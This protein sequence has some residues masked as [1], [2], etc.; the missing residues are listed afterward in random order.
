MEDEVIELRMRCSMS[1][2]NMRKG[3]FTTTISSS[4]SPEFQLRSGQLSFEKLSLY[5]LRLSVSFP[6]KNRDRLQSRWS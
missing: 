5:F 2:R 6:G 3:T 1:P 4:P